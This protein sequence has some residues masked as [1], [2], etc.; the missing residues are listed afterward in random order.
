METKNEVSVIIPTFQEEKYI[1]GTLANLVQFAPK[2]EIILVDGGSTDRTVQI[3]K[4]FADKILQI[5]ERGIS[6]A[7]NYGAKCAR[8]EIFIFLDADVIVPQ[9]F[10]RKV[11]KKFKNPNVVGATCSY[12]PSRPKLLEFIYFFLFNL[13]TRFSIAALPKTRFKYGSRGEFMAVRRSSFFEVGGFNEKIACLEDYDLTFR[14]SERGKFVFIEDLT[15]YESMRR[16]R[17]LGLSNFM[18][19]EATE[20]LAWLMYGVPRSKVWQVVR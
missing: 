4:F 19:M 8:G 20:L 18:K 2:V 7:R 13:L 6:K 17:K 5:E 12:M 3:A 1:G 15:V 11:L 14:L 10:L 9:G 16:V